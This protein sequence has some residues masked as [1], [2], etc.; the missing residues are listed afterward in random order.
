MPRADISSLLKMQIPLPPIAE[1]QRI[2]GILSDRLAAVDQARQATEAQLEAAQALPAAYLRQIFNSPEAQTWGKKPLGDV[3]NVTG[4][5]QKTPGRK[6]KDFYKPYLTVRNVQRGYL[7]LSDI[8]QF[9]L[10]PKELERYKLQ[11]GDLLIVEGNGSV[12]HIGRNAIYQGE[13][14]DC[15][16][17]NHI[18]RVRLDKSENSPE[19]ISLFLNSELGKSQMLELAETTSGLYTLSVSKVG[20]LQVLQPEHS[21]QVEVVKTLQG[22]MSQSKALAQSL[23]DQLDTIN[24]LP[25][26]FLRQAFNGE[27]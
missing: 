26:A 16:H 24:A 1:Q 5:I 17:Q 2:V 7:D 10:T 25:A 9:E 4:G 22:K 21:E 6:P 19:F 8:E 15:V 23:Q 12:N 13:I 20:R 18:I 27:L 3:A 14:Q 11:K